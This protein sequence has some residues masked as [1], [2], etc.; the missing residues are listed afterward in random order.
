MV[1]FSAVFAARTPAMGNSADRAWQLSQLV[2]GV[3]T[4]FN[5]SHG[6]LS[7]VETNCVSFASAQARKLN[8]SVCFSFPHK[9]ATLWGPQLWPDI[10]CPNRLGGMMQ[11]A[12]AAHGAFLAR[13]KLAASGSSRAPCAFPSLR[14]CPRCWLFNCL[15][16][17]SH[18]HIFPK[19]HQKERCGHS[20]PQRSLITFRGALWIIL[21]L[22]EVSA[23]IQGYH[24]IWPLSI[25]HL[26]IFLR[27]GLNRP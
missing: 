9:V 18:L 21:L 27:N 5:P 19:E 14:C 26:S 17:W 20:R 10:V 24:P 13:R 6:S 12:K 7:C 2:E 11:P 8:R 25:S 22:A 15:G 4:A 3:L 16:L 23:V 1:F